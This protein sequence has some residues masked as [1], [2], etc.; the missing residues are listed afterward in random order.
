MHQVV[1]AQLAA[2]RA[3]TQSTKTRA[4]VR[5]GGAK[6][7][8]QKGT[9]RGRAGLDPRPRTSPA[10]ASPSAPSPA[11][12]RRR[13]PRRWCASPCARP[14]PTGPPAATCSSSTPGRF[15]KPSTKDAVAALECPRHRRGADAARPRRGRR[16]GLEELPQPRRPI[17]PILA[18]EL[19]AYDVLVVRPG[20][21]HPRVAARRRQPKPTET[22]VLTIATARRSD[23]EGSPRRDHRSRSSPRRATPSST[24]ASTRSRST[25]APPSPRSTTPSRRSSGSRWPR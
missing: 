10:A 18:R 19:N 7:W 2:R 3:G 24:P 25:P 13:R 1:T 22:P 20:R 8:K 14:C 4:E 11:A 23:R 15:D 9:G 6:P 21:L 16:G 17:H 5:G 12:T